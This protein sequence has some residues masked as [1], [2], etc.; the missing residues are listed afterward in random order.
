MSP[1]VAILVAGVMIAGSIMFVNMHPAATVA[2]DPAQLPADVNVPPPTAAD[3]IIGSPSAP[4]VLVEYSDFQCP[5]CAMIYPTLKQIVSQ[6]NGQIAW[7]MR[8]FPLISIHPQARPAALAAECINAQLGN[9]AWWKFAD[10]VFA[11]QSSMS[12]AY[13]ASLAAQFGADPSKF[14]S[15]VASATYQDKL[16]QGTAEAEQN[17]GSGTPFTVVVGKGT[18]VPISGALPYA[19]IMSVISAV[20]ARQ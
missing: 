1:S 16:D 18:Q 20:K 7:V 12:P 5:Y 15:C 8:D 3:H 10:A 2:A 14:A 19:Q 9:D 11:N 17:G 6:S 13:Y 4:I